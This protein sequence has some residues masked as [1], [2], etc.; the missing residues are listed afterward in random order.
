MQILQLQ[1]P[2]CSLVPKFD[3]LLLL[4]VSGLMT[5]NSNTV[6]LIQISPRFESNSSNR[7]LVLIPETRLTDQFKKHLLSRDCSWAEEP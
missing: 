4:P 3:K 6:L 1:V 2:S 5:T 7:L